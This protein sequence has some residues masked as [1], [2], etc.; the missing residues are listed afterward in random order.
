MQNRVHARQI[1]IWLCEMLLLVGV[2][3]RT[4]C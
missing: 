3:L 4:Y 2:G 1:W